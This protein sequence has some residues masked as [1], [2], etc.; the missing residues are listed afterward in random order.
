MTDASRWAGKTCLVTGGGGFIGR[1]LIER[2]LR[3]PVTEVRALLRNPSAL[4]EIGDPRLRIHRG[5]LTDRRTLTAPASG[6]DFVFHVAGLT[7]AHTAAQFNAVNRDGVLALAEAARGGSPGLRRFLLVSSQ[8]AV[9]PTIGVDAV[10]ED[11]TPR[12][13]SHYGRSKL[14]GE[15]AL[16]AALPPSLWTVVRPPAVFGPHEKDILEVF[17]MVRRG[18]APLLGFRPKSFSIVFAPD[19]V[20]GLLRAASSPEAA[21]RTYFCAHPEPLTNVAFLELMEAALARRAF[22]PRLPEWLVGLAGAFNSVWGR[23]LKRPPLLTLQRFIEIRP[24]RWT[25]RA[26]RLDRDCGAVVYTPHAVAVR[27]TVEWY[28]RN[29][30]L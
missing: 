24:E 13:I 27:A 25:C 6:V 20:E 10:D 9:G 19:L 3:E 17:R 23:A 4:A 18:F 5:D 16:A 8:A 14:A 28:W 1:H 26:E 12:P 21:G 7:R 15:L 2:L 22:K 11:A 29:G 30:L